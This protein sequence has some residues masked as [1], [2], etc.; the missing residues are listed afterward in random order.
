L[1]C[2]ITTNLTRRIKEHN[3][4]TKGAK[5]TRSRRPVFLAWH[6]KAE[7]R[8]LASKLEYKI[9]KMSRSRKQQLIV[10]KEIL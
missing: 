1:Y 10:K 9:K 5:Y 3:E 4:T 6:Q 7:N 2:G 8:S